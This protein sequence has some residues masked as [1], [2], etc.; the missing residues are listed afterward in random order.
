MKGKLKEN[1][2]TADGALYE[3]DTVTI[4]T[5]DQLSKSYRVES[6]DGKL[7]T[8]PQDKIMLD[9]KWFYS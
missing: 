2:F 9:K 1:H 7:Y 5:I 4:H 8:V 6:Q 3:N